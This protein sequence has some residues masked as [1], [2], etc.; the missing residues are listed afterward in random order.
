M[1]NQTTAP[2]EAMANSA[3][4]RAQQEHPTLT[5]ALQETDMV[6]VRINSRTYALVKRGTDVAKV[7]KRYKKRR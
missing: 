6:S 5:E 3:P 7:K 1:E 2:Q 4:D